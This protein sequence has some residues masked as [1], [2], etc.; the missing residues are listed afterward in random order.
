MSAA[1][2]RHVSL[3][4]LL[5]A[6]IDAELRSGRWPSKRAIAIAA[7][8]APETLSQSRE[9]SSDVFTAVLGALDYGISL[10]KPPRA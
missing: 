2:V 7:G 6:A 10:V 1:R 9:V 8:V 4:T 3:R 5:D